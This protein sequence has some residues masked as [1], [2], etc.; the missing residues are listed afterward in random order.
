MASPA[1]NSAKLD[2]VRLLRTNDAARY[3][4]IGAKALRQLVMRGELP[5]VQLKPGNSP[6]L[7]DRT[8]LDRFIEARK[9]PAG[10]SHENI[11]L[12]M[13]LAR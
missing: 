1:N 5:Y 7:I 4:G 6:F 9:I 11:R 8:D 10:R 3:L 13:R 2:G 12:T